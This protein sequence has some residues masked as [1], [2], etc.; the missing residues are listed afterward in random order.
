MQ[1]HSFPWESLI[2]CP[3]QSGCSKDFY[4]L[5]IVG[6]RAFDKELFWF[7]GKVADDFEGDTARPILENMKVSV[8]LCQN[9]QLLSRSMWDSPGP[10]PAQLQL[11]APKW[12]G[13][14]G[15]TPELG[16]PLGMQVWG[17]VC[18]HQQTLCSKR[19]VSFEALPGTAWALTPGVAVSSYRAESSPA[20]E[21][22]LNAN[23]FSQK[24]FM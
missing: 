6:K 9:C 17:A 18:S 10:S 13:V 24:T 5:T 12:M 2:L 20:F 8:H 7:F 11:G 1:F 14:L 22:C 4:Q 15:H 23:A 21:C 3:T 16:R 19:T